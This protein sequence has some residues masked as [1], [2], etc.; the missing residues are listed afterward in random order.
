MVLL[1]RLIH[2][3]L[4]FFLPSSGVGHEFQK[5]SVDKSFS[6]GWSRD[7]PGQAPMRQRS[8]TT[9]GSP[10]TEKAR[11]IVRQKT[12]GKYQVT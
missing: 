4:F 8:A 11:S 12:V 1:D 5:A 3:Y 7:Q 6:R 9:T 10:G 2:N